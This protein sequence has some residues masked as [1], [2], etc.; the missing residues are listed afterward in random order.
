MTIHGFGGHM[1]KEDRGFASMAP[2]EMSQREARWAIRREQQTM[3][4]V[5]IDTGRRVARGI[6]ALVLIVAV[7]R[8]TPVHA[9][10]FISPFVGYNF[11]GDSGCPQVTN[12]E[13]KK[14]NA[15][16]AVGDMGGLLGFEE[17]FGYATN[18]FG[19]A[20]GLDSS[21]LT[22]MSD[23]M[24]APNLGP[25]RPYVLAGLGLVKTHVSLAPS[26][27]FTSD[28]NNVGWDMGGGLMGF[29]GSHL[30]VRGDLRYI[31]SF[32]DL[33]ALGFTLS[34]SKLNFGRASIGLV[35]KF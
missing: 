32:Q 34:N 25:A 10:G 3:N 35:V 16:V 5:A 27:V 23:L 29:F 11:G 19:N 1:S 14:L 9:D 31:R 20:P 8:A 30:G 33:G 28:N 6:A 26:S 21:V 12:C 2:P 24:L 18:F 15:G 22:L 13:D 7:A 17:E 4:A